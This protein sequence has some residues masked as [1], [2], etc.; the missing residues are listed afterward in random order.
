M[1]AV[2][3]DP[4]PHPPRGSKLGDL[5][6]KIHVTREEEGNSRC[7]VVHGQAGRL[8]R[9]DVGDRMAEGQCHLF[10]GG[11][12]GLAHVIAGDGDCVPVRQV[13]RAV[14]EEVG[15]QPHRRL[16]R[17][18]V[19]PAC[20]VLLEDVVL[21]RAGDL[22]RR[23]S[24]LL[25][26]ELVE[27]QKHRRGGVDRHRSRDALERDVAQQDLHVHEGVDRDAD[28]ADLAICHRIIGVV[29]DLRRQVEGDGESGLALLEQEAIPLVGF[30]GRAEPRVLAHRPEPAAVHVLVDAA[31][32]GER[33]GQLL[34]LRSGG[35]AL[36]APGAPVFHR[37]DGF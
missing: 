20:G 7:E 3:H 28:L 13:F 25:R 23:A 34:V 11:G 37:V 27:K 12:A 6:E 8:R 16:G 22:V 32:E 1:E 9:L 19:R 15:D 26:D 18:D 29:A 17:K 24:L 36:R 10:G 4:G 21:D 35:S 5:L 2:A 33:T 30:R 31:R 14:R